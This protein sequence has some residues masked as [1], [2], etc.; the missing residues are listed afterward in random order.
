MDILNSVGST[1]IPLWLA[2]CFVAVMAQCV[3]VFPMLGRFNGD[4]PTVATI[5][6]VLIFLAIPIPF[7]SF[8]LLGVF[9]AA[10]FYYF[11]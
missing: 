3:Y 4:N 6:A 2:I 1:G 10:N 9:S 8:I 7:L 5:C 11:D